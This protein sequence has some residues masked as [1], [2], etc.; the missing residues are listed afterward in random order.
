MSAHT[1]TMN[2]SRQPA[3]FVFIALLCIS[4]AIQWLSGQVIGFGTASA[5]V[6]GVGE[7]VLNPGHPLENHSEDEVHRVRRCL[8]NNG[9]TMVFKQFVQASTRFHLLC[10]EED[11]EWLDMIVQKIKG[12]YTEITSFPVKDGTRDLSRVLEWLLRKGAEK[13]SLPLP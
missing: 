8:S 13:I 10:Q 3:V 11:G 4:L 9:P 6:P 1:T 5:S 12:K 2:P 7:V